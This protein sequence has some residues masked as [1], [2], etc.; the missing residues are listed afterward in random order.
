MANSVL[1]ATYE[2]YIRDTAD[3]LRIFE[4]CL[5]G[6]LTHTARRP[7]DRE[8]S[9]LITSGNVFVYEEGSSGIK[10]WTDGV[11][12]SPSR[13]LGNFLVYREM[14]QPFSPGEKKRASKKPKKQAGVAK[15]YDH[16]PQATRFSSMPN[17]PAGVC[18]GGDGG[19]GDEDRDLV[20]S[21]TDSYDFK[22]NSLIKKTISITHNG[23]PHHL[24]SYYTVDDVRSGRL[25][26][27]SDHEFFGRVQPRMELM[28]GQNFRVPLEDGGDEE[29]RGVMSHGQQ[30]MPYP[31]NDYQIFQ[32]AY[33]NAAAPRTGQFTYGPP[34]NGTYAPV[35]VPAT[36]AIQNG[37][38]APVSVPA[39]PALQNGTY[40]PVPAPP[41][42]APQNGSYYNLHQNVHQ[43]VHQNP[44]YPW[45]TNGMVHSN[46]LTCRP[47][48]SFV[49]LFFSS[50]SSSS[51]SSHSPPPL[52]SSRPQ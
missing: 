13:I 46:L 42:P 9:T 7:H 23:I 15:A 17:D 48:P 34:Q 28:S 11:N 16:R 30:V 37:T 21:L 3:A 38:Y 8:R 50:S 2:G 1:T 20:G 5:T 12:W 40:L 14:N 10:R 52:A 44:A 26:R 39:T 36:H 18:A 31:C 27:P 41:V 22:P 19:A 24:V 45:N 32:H 33:G 25:V 29:S 51:S 43:N 35:S 4:A 6:S 47:L 49:Y